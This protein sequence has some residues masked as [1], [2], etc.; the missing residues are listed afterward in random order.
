MP[1]DEDTGGFF[2][3]TFRKIPLAAASTTGT[4]TSTT[5]TSANEE[6]AASAANDK[7]TSAAANVPRKPSKRPQLLV[8][9]RPWDSEA[10]AACASF[11]GIKEVG[12]DCFY[13]REDNM[14]GS[15]GGNG[16]SGQSKAVYYI[17]PA[18]RE[19]LSA[20][21][22]AGLKIVAAGIKVF[23]K[24]TKGAKT[25]CDYRLSQDGA[26][27][28]APYV[29]AR[30]VNVTVQDFCNL[31]GGGMV[32]FSTLAPASV[33]A[34]TPMSIGSLLCS[35]T[36]SEED[37]VTS[38]LSASAPPTMG[39]AIHTF[40]MV[41]WRGVTRAINVMCSKTGNYICQGSFLR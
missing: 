2:V 25:S 37:R 38:K 33:L 9:F 26:Y 12:N 24:K 11:Y 10:F 20:A 19:I 1:H 8:N 15:A 32:S 34:L 5:T 21:P 30:R 23:E 27:L 4:A 22:D 35:Y 6:E 13:I 29:T 7:V 16:E 17:P 3:A 41:C 36:Y 39:S 40:H 18:V 14:G 28:L 31:L